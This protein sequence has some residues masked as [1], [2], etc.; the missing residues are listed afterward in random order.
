LLPV[1]GAAVSTGTETDSFVVGPPK[2]DVLFISDVDDENWAGE[3][4]QEVILENARTFF[5][6]AANIDFRVAVTT[7]NDYATDATAEFG[8][9]LPCPT[10]SVQ[11]PTPTIISPTSMP[12]GG[13]APDPTTVFED[14]WGA[15]NTS[16]Y[17]LGNPIDEHFFTAL[18]NA[19]LHGPQPGVDFFRPG[20]FFAAITDNGDNE[21]DASVLGKGNHNPTWYANFFETYFQ[22]PFLFTWNYINPTQTITGTGFSNYLELP[23]SIQQMISVTNGFALNTADAAWAKAL[24]SVWT[25]AITAHTYY[26]LVGSPS[27]GQSSITVT[28]DG[29]VISEFAGPEEPNWTYQA[30]L[31]AI[32]FN[33]NTDP[34]KIGAQISVTYPIGCK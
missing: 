19:L 17:P 13:N 16:A 12:A 33:P 25:S 20:V 10:C 21:A 5:T 8:R 30:A 14:L 6:A 7:D 2:A 29:T 3:N 22:N 4:E 27:E 18:Y 31:D 1:T 15:V 34:P 23:P 11:G 32:V 26:P 28:V 9:L 24:T